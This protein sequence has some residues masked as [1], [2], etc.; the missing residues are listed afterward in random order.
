VAGPKESITINGDSIR[1]CARCGRQ[2]E[3]RLLMYPRPG[4]APGVQMIW[5]C[6]CR[7]EDQKKD[8]EDEPG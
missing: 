1:I 6:D 5:M 8:V 7:I 2:I 3:Y 4:P